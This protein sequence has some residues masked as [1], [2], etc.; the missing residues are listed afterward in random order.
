MSGFGC[1]IGAFRYRSGGSTGV[2]GGAM[3]SGNGIV[4]GFGEPPVCPECGCPVWELDPSRGRY[5]VAHGLCAERRRERLRGLRLGRERRDGAAGMQEMRRD[6]VL[7]QRRFRV[8]VRRGIEASRARDRALLLAVRG[9]VRLAVR[10]MNL[11]PDL[12]AM[13]V[14]DRPRGGGPDHMDHPPDSGP[15]GTVDRTVADRWI[16]H[17]LDQVWHELG[18]DAL[19]MVADD[20]G[21]PDRRP[22][23]DDPTVTREG[24]LPGWFVN[25]YEDPG[26]R[27]DFDGYRSDLDRSPS[28]FTHT[29]IVTIMWNEDSTA[30]D[31]DPE[32]LRPWK[33]RK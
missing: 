7:A 23:L 15:D 14:R 2:R 3:S 19:D 29:Q 25:D 28:P 32:R 18:T 22:W 5:R 31:H 21:W 13:T 24:S 20:I 33:P 30:D 26:D 10:A 8:A 9:D 11:R 4:R 1:D 16:V 17:R 27:L 6:L 12:V